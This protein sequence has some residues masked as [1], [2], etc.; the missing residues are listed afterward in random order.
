MKHLFVRLGA[1]VS[2]AAALPLASAPAMGANLRALE[3][4]ADQRSG[5]VARVYMRLPLGGGS[6]SGAD[7]AG[8]IH[9]L[10]PE[11]GLSL[12][13]TRAYASGVGSGGWRVE[14]AAVDAL[15]LR[16]A[17]SAAPVLWVAGQ[18]VTGLDADERLAALDTGETVALVVGALV[19]VGVGGYYF[20]RS[21]IKSD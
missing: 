6:R 19:V 1:V 8:G 2:L 17:S 5:V 12:A 18:P 21:Q 13:A 7:R 16:F 10:R 14:E 15:D 20:L 3:E 4:A 9:A 11:A